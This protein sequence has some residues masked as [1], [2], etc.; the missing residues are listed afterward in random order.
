MG[1]ERKALPNPPKHGEQDQAQWNEKHRDNLNKFR[2]QLRNM[3]NNQS[4][5]QP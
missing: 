5:Y 4:K 1:T 2:E 3:D